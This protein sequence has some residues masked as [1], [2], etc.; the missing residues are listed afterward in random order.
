MK[1]LA[2]VVA[3]AVAC[4]AVA[5]NV[6]TEQNKLDSRTR[7]GTAKPYLDEDYPGAGQA[8]A[9]SSISKGKTSAAV[10]WSE[11]FGAG[12][13]G[14]PNGAWTVSGANSNLVMYD[15]DG[16]N[17]LISSGWG[18]LPSPTSSNGF[19]I[20]DW[21]DNIPDVAGFAT[22]PAEGKL[23]SPVINVNKSDV[24]LSFYQQLFHCCNL[25]LEVFVEISTDGGA[26]WPAANRFKTN[27]T[28][29]NDR[30]WDLGYGYYFEYDISSILANGGS[31]NVKIRFNW[32]STSPDA[33][34]Q[35]SNNYFWMID[36]IKISD[37]PR[38]KAKFTD[39]GGAPAHDIIFDNNSSKTK[40]GIFTMD[41]VKPITFDSNVYNFGA[42]DQTGVDLKVEIFDASGTYM[43]SVQ[44]NN[45]S[46]LV[47][48][49][50]LD[51]D[52]LTTSAWTPPAVGTY[53]FVYTVISDSISVSANAEA[54]RDTFVIRATD[55]LTSI[56]FGTFGNSVGTAELGDDG[57]A[58][59]VRYNFDK[60][61]PGSS[62]VEFTDLIIDYSTA[63]VAGGDIQIEVYDSTGFSYTGGFGSGALL[64]RV[65][66]LGTAEDN[67]AVVRY[68]L[69]N[70][71]VPFAVPPGSYYFVVFMFSNT[72]NNRIAIANDKSFPAR[73]TSSIMFDVDAGRWYNGYVDSETFNA[74]FI[75]TVRIPATIGLDDQVRTDYLSIFPNPSR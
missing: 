55:S 5:Q 25:D 40:T 23:T 59:A 29:R 26:T 7:P 33:N 3:L 64:S 54:V 44:S 72:G 6:P 19:A 53:G 20:F 9:A 27:V 8:K 51:F 22:S 35:Y 11:D 70:N 31:N 73:G 1:K 41:E 15:M 32:T 67:G 24:F 52:D 58:M 65:Y 75:K 69:T 17:N 46:T 21:Y 43:T 39:A 30:H 36:D 16:P 18:P 57:S 56:D 14:S 74:P 37:L 2:T 62:M 68:D 66:T 13:T 34:G 63:T 71:G 4:S 47:K 60:P 49:D 38:H 48:G 10:V 50:T 42:D 61:S 12:F 45:S 28:D